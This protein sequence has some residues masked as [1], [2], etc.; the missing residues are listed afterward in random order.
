MGDSAG[1]ASRSPP[2]PPGVTIR[3]AGAAVLAALITAPVAMAQTLRTLAS[4]RQLHGESALTV[5][6]TYVAGRLH[7]TPAAPGTLY[8]MEMRYDEDKFTPVRAYDAGTGALSLGLKS[9]GHVTMDSRGRDGDVPTLD[10]AL[11]TGV[12]LALSVELGAAEADMEFGGIALAKLRFQTGASQSQVRFS[13]PNPVQCDSLTL[14]AGAAQ[15]TAAALGNA[16]CRHLRVEGGVGAIALDFTGT[17]S[18]PA[19]AQIHLALGTLKLQ[20][21]RSLGVAI[22]LDR[23]LASFDQSGF[24]RH[25]DVYYSDNYRSARYHLDV[26]VE[27]AFGGIQVLWV[28]DSR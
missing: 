25:G 15:F 6:V 11:A 3:I 26:E 12:P 16:N 21:P 19:D 9:R 5:N 1:D 20:L 27:S 10:L 22:T 7:L 18:G 4:S 8:Q 23:F 14:E 17:W 2:G 28:N 24:T 13:R